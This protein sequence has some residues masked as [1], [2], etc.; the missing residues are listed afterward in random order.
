MRKSEIDTRVNEVPILDCKHL[1]DVRELMRDPTNGLEIDFKLTNL[2]MKWRILAWNV[3]ILCIGWPSQ[4]SQLETQPKAPTIEPNI[5]YPIQWPKYNQRWLLCVFLITQ[6]ST[7][8]FTSQAYNK[9]W[10]FEK[11][12]VIRCSQKLPNERKPL[13]ICFPSN[14]GQVFTP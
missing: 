9:S 10:Y 4:S 12:K 11:R 1:Y 5:F 7:T 2:E 6:E 8:Q 3:K 13:D 14:S